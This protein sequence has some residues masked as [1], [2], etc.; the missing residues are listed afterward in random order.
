[1]GK[2]LFAV[3]LVIVAACNGCKD[4]VEDTPNVPVPPAIAAPQPIM[5]SVDSVYPHDPKAF[6][7]GLEFYKG[8]FYEGT[9]QYEESTLRIVDIKTGNVEKKYLIPDT[10]I[11]GEGIT[12]F[13]DKIYQLTWT[14]HKVFVYNLS[15]ITKPIKTLAW[16]YEGWGI[17]HDDS[18][19]IISDGSSNIYFVSPDDLHVLKK[20]SVA[21]NTG[22]ED[23]LNELELINGYIFANRWETNDIFK[24]DTSNGHIVGRMDLTGLLAQYAAK[25]ITNKTNVLNGIA[26]D[27][28]TKKLYITGKNWPKMFQMRINN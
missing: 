27:S 10:S 26:Y 20:I 15:D 4:K 14:S 19:L 7:Q 9:G 24:I 8:K 1:M 3:V 6:I 18:R 28:T 12:I 16:P 17:T 2:Y 22:P 23:R 13:K 5:F 11:F 21:D 25:D